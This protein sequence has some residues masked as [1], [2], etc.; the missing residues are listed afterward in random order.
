VNVY[1]GVDT[2]HDLL[3][4]IEHVDGGPW[5]DTPT[6]RLLKKERP[7]GFLLRCGPRTVIGEFVALLRTIVLK[8]D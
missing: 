6:G 4:V 2:D 5:F 1:R 7:A 3:A 8:P